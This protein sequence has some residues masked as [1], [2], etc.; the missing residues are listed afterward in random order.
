M[1]MRMPG[2]QRVPTCFRMTAPR[3]VSSSRHFLRHLTRSSS[4]SGKWSAASQQ[5]SHEV[6]TLGHDDSASRKRMADGSL[7]PLLHLSRTAC[8]YAEEAR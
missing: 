4:R 7:G 3:P 8:G 5:V 1:L 2:C 6:V